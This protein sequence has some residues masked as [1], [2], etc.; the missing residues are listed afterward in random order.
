MSSHNPEN[1]DPEIQKIRSRNQKNRGKPLEFA[2]G[3]A[4]PEFPKI[5]SGIP[6]N[7]FQIKGQFH[8]TNLL[9][10]AS[11]QVDDKNFAQWELRTRAWKVSYC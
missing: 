3:E 10:S 7:S 6:K 9:K 5:H 4:F 2:G 1:S 11:W 8:S